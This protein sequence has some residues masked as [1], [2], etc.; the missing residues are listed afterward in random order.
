MDIMQIKNKVKSNLSERRYLHT[1]RV[2]ELAKKLA[3]TYGVSVGCVEKASLIHDYLKETSNEGLKHIIE[4]SNEQTEILNEHPIL[5]HGPAAASIAEKE[6]GITNHSI[7]QAIRYHTIGRPEMDLVEQI[8]FIADYMEPA[9]TFPGIEDVRSASEK[10]LEEAI[11]LALGNTI[12][13]L[14]KKGASIHSMTFM[15]YN[16]Y[17]LKRKWHQNGGYRL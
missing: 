2:A 17:L 7:L 12:I 15:A 1:L 6:F 11:L 14:I 9:R 8:V 10:S 5:W 13:H 16:A 3:V 4:S